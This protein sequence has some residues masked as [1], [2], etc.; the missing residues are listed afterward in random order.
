VTGILC[1]HCGR[2]IALQQVRSTFTCPNCKQRLV[3]NTT[4]AA[5]VAAAL[6]LLPDALIYLFVK[7]LII[8]VALVTL[9]AFI[10]LTWSIRRFS[11]VRGDTAGQL[12]S[13]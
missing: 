2:A 9:F 8:R 3:A 7:N 6:C 11:D 1:P 5:L 12:N 13:R 4:R 10:A